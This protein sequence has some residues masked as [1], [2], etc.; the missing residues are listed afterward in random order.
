MPAKPL[1]EVA[2][3]RAARAEF[4]HDRPDADWGALAPSLKETYR[5]QVRAV[6]QFRLWFVATH[7]AAQNG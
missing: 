6:D 1:D 5:E 4:L 7:R 3:E 2:I